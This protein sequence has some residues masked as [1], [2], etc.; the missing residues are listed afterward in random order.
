MR[1]LA[2]IAIL[3]WATASYADPSLVV[4]GPPCASNIYTLVMPAAPSGYRV[5]SGLSTGDCIR[6]KSLK[7]A[8]RARTYCATEFKDPSEYARFPVPCEGT[9]TCL[10]PPVVVLP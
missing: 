2:S 9:I 7:Q 10:R 3:F 1:R 6:L 8:D 4:F 5:I